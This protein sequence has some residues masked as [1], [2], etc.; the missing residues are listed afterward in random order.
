MSTLYDF[1]STCT[2]FTP[3]KR[4]GGNAAAYSNLLLCTARKTNKLME[5]KNTH[6]YTVQYHTSKYIIVEEPF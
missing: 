3:T 6:V 5:H 1:L 4:R 2:D